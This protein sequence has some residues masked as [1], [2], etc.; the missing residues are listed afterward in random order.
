MA[1]YV[2]LNAAWSEEEQRSNFSWFNMHADSALEAAQSL[3]A[4]H[5]DEVRSGT[6]HVFPADQVRVVKVVNTPVWTETGLLDRG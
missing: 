6:F 1:L 4:Q 3:H 2:V 5:P